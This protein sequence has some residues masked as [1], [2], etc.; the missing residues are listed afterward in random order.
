MATYTFIPQPGQRDYYILQSVPSSANGKAASAPPAPPCGAT[1]SRGT[2]ESRICPIDSI[3][4]AS[5]QELPTERKMLK[6][7]RRYVSHVRKSHPNLEH[8]CPYDAWYDAFTWAEH[9]CGRSDGPR[10][11][12]APRSPKVARNSVERYH[13][14]ACENEWR[15]DQSDAT[16]AA[17]MN[18]PPRVPCTFSFRRDCNTTPRGGGFSFSFCNACPQPPFPALMYKI[19]WKERGELVYGLLALYPGM[20]VEYLDASEVPLREKD[21]EGLRR[22]SRAMANV[23]HPHPPAHRDIS[24]LTQ[25]GISWHSNS[26]QTE[27]PCS[28]ISPSTSTSSS[29]T[30]LATP[31]A[32]H[33]KHA[34]TLPLPHTA[35]TDTSATGTTT[36]DTFPGAFAGHDKE[37]LESD[38]ASMSPHCS[39]NLDTLA[40]HSDS[41][42]SRD[43][44]S[45]TGTT[46]SGSPSMSL[47][48]PDDIPPVLP[49]LK[50]L[51]TTPEEIVEVPS[52]G[53]SPLVKLTS[54]HVWRKNKPRYIDPNPD[55][56]SPHW[57]T[58]D[59]RAAHSAAATLVVKPYWVHPKLCSRIHTLMRSGTRCGFMEYSEGLLNNGI[60]FFFMFCRAIPSEQPTYQISATI[61]SRVMLA[62]LVL[63]PEENF[64]S[65]RNWLSSKGRKNPI[66]G[67]AC[68]HKGHM[69]T[70]WLREDT[71]LQHKA[72]HQRLSPTSSSPSRQS[73]DLHASRLRR[74]QR[75]YRPYLGWIK[76]MHAHFSARPPPFARL[77]EHQLSQL[78]YNGTLPGYHTGY[79]ALRID[80]LMTSLSHGRTPCG[81]SDVT[82]NDVDARCSAARATVLLGATMPYAWPVGPQNLMNEAAALDE[83][84]GHGQ[85]QSTAAPIVLHQQKPPL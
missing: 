65:I 58:R 12:S 40:A 66:V 84:P 9:L 36:E 34:D 41:D 25:F 70:G 21:V 45:T 59:E 35:T 3:P 24:M 47:T 73:T 30:A 4:S 68:L 51:L 10:V 39:V 57:G 77:L 26:L 52:D 49:E 6:R 50:F 69:C 53:P 75:Q 20:S 13:I 67:I 72:S 48:D 16:I 7:A 22:S 29:L 56:L 63:Y 2:I 80:H 82:V 19:S 78:M 62:E 28:A 33:P 18:R 23:Q 8:I 61:G 31:D 37:S 38:T 1:P 55:V 60:A 46:S 64:V 71:S 54:P 79:I 43:E 17:L 5:R 83:F 44:K 27:A 15:P 76:V 14:R 81:S 74:T 32:P 85:R 42:R 11:A